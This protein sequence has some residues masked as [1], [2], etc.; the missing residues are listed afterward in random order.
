[1]I[2][3]ATSDSMMMEGVLIAVFGFAISLPPPR[4]VG[5]AQPVHPPPANMRLRARRR[6]PETRQRWAIQ[7]GRACDLR[8]AQSRNSCGLKLQRA[9]VH[10]PD[11]VRER[12]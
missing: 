12:T 10:L 5:L 8:M 2:F 4:R 7:A 11:S 6:A 3:R 1:R 9:S